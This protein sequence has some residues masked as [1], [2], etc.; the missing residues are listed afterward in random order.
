M[1][2]DYSLFRAPGPGPMASW[3]AAPPEPLG[4]LE[5]IQQRLSAVFPEAI[6]ERWDG[7]HFGRTPGG[8]CEFQITPD[9]DGVC[10][11]L[12]VRRVTRAE[13]EVLCRALDVVAVDAQKTELIRP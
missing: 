8:G 4:T 7:S 9:G 5:Q 10:R 1:S 2:C 13:V 11:F 6:W 3:Q 12:T